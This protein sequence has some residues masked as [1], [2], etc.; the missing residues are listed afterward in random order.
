[1]AQDS[2]KQDLVTAI[3]YVLIGM[4]SLGAVFF[5]FPGASQTRTMWLWL[6]IATGLSII[7]LLIINATGWFRRD[8]WQTVFP[9]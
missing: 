4:V 9:A 2:L 7:R 6:I 8:Q 1:M 5:W 3:S